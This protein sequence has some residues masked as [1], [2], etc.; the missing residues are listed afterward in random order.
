MGAG[1]SWSMEPRVS[2]KQSMVDRT[3]GAA[4]FHLPLSDGHPLPRLA[5]EPGCLPWRPS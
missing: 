4:E 1:S 2:A 3:L 5:S